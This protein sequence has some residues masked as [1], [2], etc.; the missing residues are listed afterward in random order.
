[1]LHVPL[2]NCAGLLNFIVIYVKI[3]WRLAEN[4]GHVVDLFDIGITN[5]VTVFVVPCILIILKFFS[6][7]N[8][9]FIKNK[10]KCSNLQLKYLCIRCYMFGPS[11]PS[12]GSLR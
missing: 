6:P 9:L 4:I 12:S 1:M 2:F 3:T 7:T 10:K 8:A 11:G 5:N